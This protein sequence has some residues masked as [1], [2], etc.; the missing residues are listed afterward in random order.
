MTTPEIPAMRA[1]KRA[2]PK[3]DLRAFQGPAAPASSAPLASDAA[4]ALPRRRAYPRRLIDAH[5]HLWT[6]Q[7]LDDGDMQWQRGSGGLDQLKGPHELE[8]YAEVTDEAMA[9]VGDGKSRHAG[10][11]YVQAEAR[12]DDD[13]VD[14]S[15]GG[16]EAAINEVESV[17]AAAL[18]ADVHLLAL[19]PWAPVQHGA[20]ALERYIPRLLECPSLVALTEKLGY[21]PIKSFRY[22]LQDSP[23][24]FFGT[25]Q[26]IEGFR[27]LGE[28]GYAFDMTLD[29]T[30]EQTGRTKILEDAIDVI[31][32]VHRGQASEQQT[33]FIFD[34]FAKPS[35]TSDLSY[36]PP[37]HHTAYLETL[38][39]LALVPHTYLKLSALLDSA[40]GPTAH[41]AFGEFKS[42]EYRKR[43]RRDSAYQRLKAR[44][45]AVLEP[46]IEAFGDERILVGSDWPMFRATLLPE[47]VT[48]PSRA[49]CP[50]ADPSEEAR[51]WAFEMQLYLD[52]LVHLGLD[53]EAL[54]R[55]F[56]T[57][58][59]KVYSLLPSPPLTN[60]AGT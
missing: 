26:F 54:D 34:H 39:Q 43:S 16:W 42:G 5:I 23:P 18:G 12:R 21:S 35:L 4:T 36:P 37:S 2:P 57:N 46:A 44:I 22:L 55:I 13:D 41:A 48:S 10:V 3:L 33:R 28:R 9:L 56:E 27:Y 45:L 49:H 47:S 32:R 58:A 17:C 38:F 50:T 53:G 30:H 8:A 1:G 7:Q 19:V 52:C 60:T 51:A 11:I 14:G 59:R 31:E 20:A 6:K 29:V 25:E 24:G 15:R 40:D